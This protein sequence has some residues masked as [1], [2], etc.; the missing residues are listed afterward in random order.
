M[1]K[2][3]IGQLYSANVF[4][5]GYKWAGK[6]IAGKRYNLQ[7]ESLHCKKSC[8]NVLFNSKVLKNQNVIYFKKSGI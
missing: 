5:Y 7:M 6:C 2:E 1:N 3:K 8:L 4:N